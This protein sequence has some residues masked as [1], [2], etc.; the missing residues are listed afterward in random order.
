[1]AVS[2]VASQGEDSGFELCLSVLGLCVPPVS[3][4]VPSIAPASSNSLKLCRG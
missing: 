1:M 2:T 4:W 3:V